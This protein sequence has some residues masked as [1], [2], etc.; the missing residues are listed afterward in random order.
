MMNMFS[1]PTHVRCT[2]DVA[3]RRLGGCGSSVR[4]E[5]ERDLYRIRGTPDSVGVSVEFPA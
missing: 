5:G 4:S 1:Q 2:A 3:V